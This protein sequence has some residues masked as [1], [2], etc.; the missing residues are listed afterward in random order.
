MVFQI[1]AENP[2]IRREQY[3]VRLAALLGI[4]ATTLRRCLYACK[5]ESSDRHSARQAVSRY[6]K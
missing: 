4:H 6:A 3:E 2:L 1:D 5:H